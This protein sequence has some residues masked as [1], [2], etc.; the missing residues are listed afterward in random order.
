MYIAD[1][2]ILGACLPILRKA[3]AE[4]S[5]TRPF[6]TTQQIWITLRRERH[7]I[8]TELLEYYQRGRDNGQ[9]EVLARIGQ[10]L[11]EAPYVETRY[12][13]ARYVLFDPIEDQEFGA[14]GR[15]CRIF[16]LV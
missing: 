16:R 6:L 2:R 5:G 3:R 4:Q 9:N 14:G 7:R 12:L 1:E 10:A 11:G 8:C 15:S 13:D